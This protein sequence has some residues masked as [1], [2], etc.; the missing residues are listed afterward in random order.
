[1]S[2]LPRKRAFLLES[3][4]WL[5]GRTAVL[6]FALSLLT[7]ALYLLGNFQDYLDSTQV[8]LLALLRLALLAGILA[9]LTFAA[10]SLALGRPKAGRLILCFLLVV[11]SGALLLAAGFLSAWFQLPN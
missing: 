11:Y 5:A 8:L 3:L 7:L 6:C 10:V 4:H 2:S 9:A 1:V